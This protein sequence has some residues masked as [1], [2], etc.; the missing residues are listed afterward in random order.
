[1]SGDLCADDAVPSTTFPKR[2]MFC[3][4][5]QDRLDAIREHIQDRAWSNN[6]RNKEGVLTA[7]CETPGCDNRPIYGGEFCAECQGDN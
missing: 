2:K 5:H 6:V 4:K 1:M 7:F 3:Q